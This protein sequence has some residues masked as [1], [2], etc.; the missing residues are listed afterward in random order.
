MEPERRSGWFPFNSSLHRFLCWLCLPLINHWFRSQSQILRPTVNR[1]AFPGVRPPSGPMTNFSFSLKFSSDSCG[2][3]ILWSPTWREDG[4][5]IYCCCWASSAQFFSSLR[6]A[7]LKTKFYYLNFWDSP[8]MEGQ[9]PVCTG[10]GKL[11][12][13][14]A[15]SAIWKKEASLPHPLFPSGAG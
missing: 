12:S 10:C 1:P 11:T 4:S 8:N 7:G 15:L 13:F 6:P 3:D 9:F 14:F 5:V 2:F